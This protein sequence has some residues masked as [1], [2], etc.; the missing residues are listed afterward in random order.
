M[1]YAAQW[2]ALSSRIHG[3]VQAGK[4]DALYSS[5]GGSNAYGTTQCI[6][7]QA[8][9]I[10]TGIEYFRDSLQDSIT[11]TAKSAASRFIQDTAMLIR[12]DAGTRELKQQQQVLRGTCYACRLRV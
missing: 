2:K 12:N 6:I 1:S 11:P 10:L 4:L 5:V 9:S 3:L 7:D 8:K